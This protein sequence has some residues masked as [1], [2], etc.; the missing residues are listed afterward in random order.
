MSRSADVKPRRMGRLATRIRDFAHHVRGAAAVEFSMV[1]L[2][3]LGVVFVIMEGG[4]NGWATTSL[5]QA[6]RSATRQIQTGQAQETGMTADNFRTNIC[7]QLPSFMSCS[8]LF[9]DVQAVEVDDFDD[10]FAVKKTGSRKKAV[11]DVIRPS[12]NQ[13]SNAFCPGSGSDYIVVR[14]IY[15]VPNIVGFAMSSRATY[16]GK[17]VHIIESGQ[18]FRNEPFSAAGPSC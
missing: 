12:L 16:N 2:P 9:V 13:A 14:A 5:D 3:F 8:G 4:F 18:A 11:A 17:T 1:A 6:V 15:T 10:L 7:R